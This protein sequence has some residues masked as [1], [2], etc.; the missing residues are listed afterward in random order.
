MDYTKMDLRNSNN[1]LLRRVQRQVDKKNKF[2]EQEFDLFKKNKNKNKN[3][4]L[5]NFEDET[6]EQ[7]TFNV[8]KKTRLCLFENRKGKR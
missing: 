4:L 3:S 2:E 8:S 7:Q 6:E 5:N 1:Q